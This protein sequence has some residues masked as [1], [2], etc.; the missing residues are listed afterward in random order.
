MPWTETAPGI[1]CG[2]DA[3]TRFSK[4]D[5]D[6][7]VTHARDNPKRRSRICAHTTLDDP[8]HEMIICLLGDGYVQPHRH[9]K[10]ESLH[11]IEGECDLI[12][13]DDAGQISEITKLASTANDTL[14][15][16]MAP[17]TFHTLCVRSEYLVFHETVRG[18][19]DRA[20]TEHA[21]WAPAEDDTQ[22]VPAYLNDLDAAITHFAATRA[23][24]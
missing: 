3:T 23:T 4:Q 21:A 11:V 8:V 5:V 17:R 6:F 19:F 14:Y 10:P 16:R 18:P 9:N 2:D 22:A 24:E 20:D 13:F 7:L 15:A 1:F 12:F